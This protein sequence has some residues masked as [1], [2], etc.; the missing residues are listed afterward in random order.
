MK[1]LMT[2]IIAVMAISSS[3]LFAQNN[4]GFEGRARGATNHCLQD[5]SG[6]NWDLWTT[7]GVVGTCFVEGF[8]YEVNFVARPNQNLCSDCPPAMPIIVATVRFDCEG[9]IIYN[10]CE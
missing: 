7:S 1:K 6:P 9:N 2:T 8:I 5:Y 3:G 4:Q 10:S